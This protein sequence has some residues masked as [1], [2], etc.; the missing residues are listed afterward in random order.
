M[1]DLFFIVL[2]IV[3]ISFGGI[4]W[5]NI[6][7]INKWIASKGRVIVMPV[8]VY[9]KEF[10]RPTT[11]PKD[12]FK[13]SIAA[14]KQGIARNPYAQW[15]HDNYVAWKKKDSS[16]NRKNVPRDLKCKHEMFI[17]SDIEQCVDCCD[18]IA[19]Q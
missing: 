6:K 12:L 7:H 5:Y 2:E 3:L 18:K 17:H 9:G 13:E 10:T 4:V 8:L 16:G 11:I 19:F 14:M 1:S 15:K